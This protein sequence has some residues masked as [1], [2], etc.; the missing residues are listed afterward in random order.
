MQTEPV[1]FDWWKDPVC[2]DFP[3]FYSLHGRVCASIPFTPLVIVFFNNKNFEIQFYTIC[4]IFVNT[5]KVLKPGG[6]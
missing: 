2:G 3:V 5:P 4:F 6:K 1:L